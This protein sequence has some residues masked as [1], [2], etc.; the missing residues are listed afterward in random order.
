[1]K[2]ND[3]YNLQSNTVYNINELYSSST[4]EDDLILNKS[5]VEYIDTAETESA[6]IAM[7]ETS[8]LDKTLYSS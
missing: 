3:S 1:M 2:K 6:Y 4:T 7:Q 5:I 8:E